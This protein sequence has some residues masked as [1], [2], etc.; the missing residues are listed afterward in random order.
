M[1]VARIVDEHVKRAER[2]L[3]ERDGGMRRVRVPDIQFK[4]PERFRIA[5]RQRMQRLDVACGCDT[6]SKSATDGQ[7]R[8]ALVFAV[9]C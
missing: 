9:E 4:G 6:R 2:F 8:Q 5:L 1:G 3:H 7:L